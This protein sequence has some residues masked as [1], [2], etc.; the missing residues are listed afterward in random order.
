MKPA[1]RP[2]CPAC[3]GAGT[4]LHPFTDSEV[5]CEHC[6]GQGFDPYWMGPDKPQ[7]DA[8]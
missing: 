7:G 2:R 3:Y 8:E 5:R 6:D 4:I 1:S